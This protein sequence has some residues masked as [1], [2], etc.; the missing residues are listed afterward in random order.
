M[1][2]NDGN[3]T[4][5]ARYHGFCIDLLKLIAKAVGFYYELH[6]VPD[7]KYGVYDLDTGQWNGMVRELID[8]VRTLHFF[9]W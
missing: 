6:L 5:N 1:L 7:N 9:S 4:G 2:H 3:M 8:Q